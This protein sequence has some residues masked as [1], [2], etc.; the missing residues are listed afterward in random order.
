M[1][2]AAVETFQFI[3]GKKT[4]MKIMCKAVIEIETKFYF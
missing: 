4:E 2:K 1:V 3:H